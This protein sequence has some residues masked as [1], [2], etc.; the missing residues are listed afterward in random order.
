MVEMV[1]WIYR[2][3]ID[4]VSAPA[5]LQKEVPNESRKAKSRTSLT[6]KVTIVVAFALVALIVTLLVIVLTK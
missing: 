3:A 5:P 2:T 4:L 6:R 1:Y